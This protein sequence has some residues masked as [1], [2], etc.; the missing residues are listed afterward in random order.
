MYNSLPGFLV[1]KNILRKDSWKGILFCARIHGKEYYSAPGFMVEDYY[2]A[3]GF[4]VEKNT[5]CKAL[6]RGILFC[7]RIHVEEYYSAPG[8]MVKNIILRQDS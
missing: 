7:T 5:L 6:W 2:S 1:E 8:F 3:P 4:M